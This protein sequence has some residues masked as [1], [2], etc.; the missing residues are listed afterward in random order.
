MAI[1]PVL[2]S[3]ALLH[4]NKKCSDKMLH[5]VSVEPPLSIEHPDY[6]SNT[7]LSGLTWHLLVRLR[8]LGSFLVILELNSPSPIVKWCMNKSLKIP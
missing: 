5:P 7:L 3:E 6:K 4:E 8:L 1:M 2:A